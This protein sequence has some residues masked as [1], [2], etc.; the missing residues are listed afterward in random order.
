MRIGKIG[1][2][3]EIFDYKKMF[4]KYDNVIITEEERSYD[5]SISL[6]ESIIPSKDMRAYHEKIGY[7]YDDFTIAAMISWSTMPHFRK[8]DEL[9]KV[10]KSTKD[11]VLKTQLDSYIDYMN[12][13]MK[14]VK[15]NPDNEFIYMLE[16]EWDEGADFEENGYFLNFEDALDFSMRAGNVRKS[17]TKIRPIR[18]KEEYADLDQDFLNN[19]FGYV[20]YE[21]D[22]TIKDCNS[23][24]VPEPDFDMKGFNTAYIHIPYPFRDGDV[25]QIVT[26]NNSLGI[27]SG[28]KTEEEINEFYEK[29]KNDFDY[30]DYQ[31]T[32]EDGWYD[33]ECKKYLW[34]HQ[35]VKPLFIEYANLDN[36]EWDTGT[37]LELMKVAGLLKKGDSALSELQYYTSMYEKKCREK[38]S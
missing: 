30:S 22:G 9:T 8:V 14:G 7:T 1:N 17:I 27:V 36:I 26:Q 15:Y 34:G 3:D 21:K 29:F 16:V 37:E 33:E 28:F 31:I 12:Y 35:H 24:D 4:S 25:I 18:S 38:K 19:D 6:M 32:I 10:M 13:S 5:S 23:Y 20:L 2:D 11:E